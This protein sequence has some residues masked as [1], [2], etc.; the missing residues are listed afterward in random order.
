MFFK[1]TREDYVTNNNLLSDKQ[2]GFRKGHSTEHAVIELVHRIY[3]SFNENK[4][5]LAVS[6]DLSKAFDTVNHKN[7]LKKLKLYGIE[8]SHLKWFSSC[9]S[10][11]E[12]Y[13][14]NKYIKTSH[15]DIICGVPQGSIL[16]PLFFIIYINDLYNVSNILQPIMFADDTN[17]FSSHSNIKDFLMM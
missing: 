11:I 12:K 7:L 16:G 17:L 5:T 13:I 3:N 2:F 4:Y 6:I 14:E 8:N 1:D 10:R 15:L 9:L